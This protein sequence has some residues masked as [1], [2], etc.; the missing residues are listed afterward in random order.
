MLALAP[1]EV[2]GWTSALNAS[3]ATV[4]AR[5]QLRAGAA[6]YLATAQVAGAVLV[7]NDRELWQRGRGAV[8]VLT[9]DEWLAAAGG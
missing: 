1:L 3:A 6:C 5:W 8:P 4:A 2:T 9:P 7:T